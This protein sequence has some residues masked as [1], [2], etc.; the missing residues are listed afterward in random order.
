[1]CDALLGAIAQGDIG[2]HFP[3]SDKEF[4]HIDSRILLRQVFS[5]VKHERLKIGNIDLTIIAQTPKLAPYLKEM[6]IRIASDL[7]ADVSQVN[8]KATTTEGMGFAGRKEGIEAH[9]VV[10]LV[11]EK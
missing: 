10:L 9:A 11:P 6:A 2:Q 3:D 7:G 1:M 5:L 4:K 8:I